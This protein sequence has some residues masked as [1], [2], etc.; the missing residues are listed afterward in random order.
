M[1]DVPIHD[2]LCPIRA[3]RV[4]LLLAVSLAWSLS[5]A[6]VGRQSVHEAALQAEADYRVIAARCG[7]PG[8]EKQ[9]FK[10]SRATVAAGLVVND[11]NLAVVEK[12]IE[13]RRRNPLRLVS[14]GADCAEKM[15]VLKGVQLKRAQSVRAARR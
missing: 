4:G 2:E 12:R 6:D 8:F 9:F 1:N 3:G 10:Q 5:Y 13:A 11:Q 14:T 7:T 15:A